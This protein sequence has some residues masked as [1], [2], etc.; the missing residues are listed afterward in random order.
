MDW[1]EERM[2]W[3]AG[4][5]GGYIQGGGTLKGWSGETYREE[6]RAKID[7]L[8]EQTEKKQRELH[9]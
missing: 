8:R 2:K 4:N 1:N 3:E 9:F 5:G 6:L 7:G